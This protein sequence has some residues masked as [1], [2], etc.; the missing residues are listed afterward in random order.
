MHTRHWLPLCLLLAAC[1][2]GGAGDPPDAPDAEDARRDGAS[3]DGPGD[4]APALDGPAADA[5]ALD[6]TSTADASTFRFLCE[7]P[8]PVGAPTPVIPPPPAAGCPPL[9]AGANQLMSSGRMRSF[10][11]VVPADLAPTERP[12]VLFMWHWL[13][14]SAQSFR[15]RGEVQAAADA[16][17]FI[18]VLP[19][20]VGATVLGT[21]FDTRWPFDI[22]QTAARMNEEFRFFDD[23]LGCVAAQY[24]VNP[25]CVSSIGVSAGAL[26]TD[27]LAQ[28]R[29]QTLAS[30]VSLSGGTGASIIKPWSGAA[31]PLPGLV[32]WGGDG[33]PTMD[34]VK[35]ILG[36]F[37]IGMDF[38][39]ASRNLESGLT[40]GGHFVVECR[41][42]C[43]HVEP[44]LTPPAGVSKYAGIWEFA[45]DHPFWL[46][47]GQ[48]PWTSEGLPAALPSWCA[49]GVGTSAPRTGDGCPAAENPCPS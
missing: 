38:S 1:G 39:V 41:H 4:D 17:R 30:F 29:A 35:D 15:D 24:Q 5:S 23:M 47:A 25:S 40:S 46:A 26:F 36:C 21:A 20:S 11:L 33:P 48:S 32:L 43:G 27:Q 12:P 34:G 22:T 14:G 13:G 45:L 49:I 42:N 6:A 19:V 10:L 18:A 2:G 28:A 37:G 7:A 44:P 16:Q 8:P 9:A 31:R 3:P